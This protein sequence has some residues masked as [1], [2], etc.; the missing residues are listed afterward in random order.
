MPTR[1]TNLPPEA[2]KIYHITHLDNLPSLAEH[3]CLWSDA[4]MLQQDIGKTIIGLSDIK[5]RRMEELEVHCHPGTK[6][7]EYVPFYFCP[8][9]IMLYIL[10]RGNAP[11]LTYTGGQRPIVHL[12]ADLYETVQWAEQEGRRWAF[13]TS[14][15]GARYVDFFSSL[16][17]LNKIDWEAVQS[18]DFS[19]SM[20]KEG[21]QAEFLLYELFP[22]H[23]FRIV[24]VIDA[25]HAALAAQSL[26][27]VADK[28]A[29]QIKREWY[30]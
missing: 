29:I 8:R 16:P 26:A 5:R 17:N 12:E 27:Q 22:F 4:R 24:G 2:P 6:V 25:D 11:G 9:S 23:L 18:N 7:G 14:N 30:F 21:K 28:P 20:V 15:A 19:T 1:E 3:G 10:Y 13:S